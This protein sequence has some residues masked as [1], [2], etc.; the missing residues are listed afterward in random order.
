MTSA[1]PPGEPP[2]PPDPSAPS[3]LDEVLRAELDHIFRNRHPKRTPDDVN[4]T[5]IGLALSGGGIR[6]A[7][8]NLGVLQA[9]SHMGMLPLVDYLSTVSGGGY[10]GACLSSLLSWNGDEQAARTPGSHDPYTFTREDLRFTTDWNSFP[11]R[12]E[13]IRGKSKVGGELVGH[14][15]THGN[16]LVS[17]L[18][19]LT[20]E[21]MRSIGSIIT[22]V[23][24][25]VLAFL[26]TMFAISAVYLS[27]ALVVSPD[28]RQALDGSVARAAPVDLRPRPLVDAGSTT[29]RIDTGRGTCAPGASGCVQETRTALHP[30]TLADRLMRNA[31]VT[32]LAFKFAA[33]EWA[34]CG[35]GCLPERGAA[36]VIPFAIGA[37]FSIVI[38]IWI[39]IARHKYIRGVSPIGGEPKRGESIEDA[40]EGRVLRRIAIV[41]LLTALG[42]LAAERWWGAPLHGA[43]QLLW[44]FVVAAFFLG[45]RVSSFLLAVAVLPGMSSWTRRLRSLWGA[46][47][48]ITIY[49]WWVAFIAALFPLAIYALRDHSVAVG[50]SAFGSLLVTRLVVPRSSGGRASWLKIL[51]GKFRNALLAVLVTLVVACCVLFFGSL[52]A[53]YANSAEGSMIFAA[54]TVL[55]LVLFAMFADQNKLG[56]QYF[57]RDRIAETYL[58]SEM[59]D[60]N[61]AMRVYRDAMEMPLSA[62]HGE[63]TPLNIKW[64]NTAPYHLVSAAI[65]LAGSRDLTRKDRKSGYWLFSK[66]YCGSTHTGFRE[67]KHYRGGETKLA[68]AIAISGAAA[69][70]GI[71]QGTFFAQ[72]FATVMFNIRLGYWLQ[73]PMHEGSITGKERNTFWPWY[74]WREV[75]MNT[76]ETARLVNLSDG[77]H[78]GD[79][80]GIYPLLQRRCKVII[81]CDS[82]QDPSLTFSSFTEALRH[83]YVDLGIDVDI[84]LTMIRPDPDT[85][86]SRSHCAVGRIRY[87]D[88]PDQES[89]LIYI[90][91]S[92]TGDEPEPVLNYKARHAEF[93][94]QTTVD[95]FFDDAQFESYR[96]LGVHLAEHTFNGWV[97]SRSFD[98]ILN[99]HTP[100]PVPVLSD[101]IILV[102]RIVLKDRS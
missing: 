79:N 47:Q 11:F 25:N 92:L 97:R 99:V 20:R 59:A 34:A 19:L 15:R 18:G 31:T 6:S 9:L 94:H 52:L 24:F 21:T 65:N 54:G 50:W 96:A 74:L 33:A 22:G 14:L 70:S 102:P 64:R 95:Q 56:P 73:N 91:N 101:R 93:P 38:W 37:L 35:P 39:L 83:A 98:E 66:L 23:A 51:S 13:Y 29:T 85:G 57:Y 44:L 5:F 88:R 67:T 16:F 60:T 48:T 17:R 4:R 86:L 78:T 100:K 69:S 28:M 2:A 3:E 90:K 41:A 27:I 76:T 72:A 81:A 32:A 12:A 1:T 53:A 36:I 58:L 80:V 71:G 26:L 8:A 62:L 61:G 43:S 45:A 46:Y 63:A 10:I 77:G 89:Y 40:L 84:D 30:P 87:P 68:R 82:E 75:T 49:G 42:T 55:V 7:T